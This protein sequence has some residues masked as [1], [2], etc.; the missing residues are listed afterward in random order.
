MTRDEAIRKAHEIDNSSLSPAVRLIAMLEYLGL[1]TFDDAA[2][3]TTP[4]VTSNE[5]KG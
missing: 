2:K 4:A 3:P 1:L 5:R